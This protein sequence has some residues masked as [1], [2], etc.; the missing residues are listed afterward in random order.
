MGDV[1]VNVKKSK[2]KFTGYLCLGFS[3]LLSGSMLI[4]TLDVDP[5][6]ALP[7]V[8]FWAGTGI[9]LLFGTSAK[10]IVGNAQM[11]KKP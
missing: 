6:I 8:Y 5:A 7:L 1:T 4:P 3:A 2:M 10:H 9:T 11:S